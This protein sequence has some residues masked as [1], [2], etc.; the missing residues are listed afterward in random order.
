MCV[1]LYTAGVA[2][3]EA[4]IEM[5]DNQCPEDQETRERA[6]SRLSCATSLTTMREGY[7]TCDHTVSAG[8]QNWLGHPG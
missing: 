1:A 6:A 8:S 2:R 5:N 3:P 4:K 7:L